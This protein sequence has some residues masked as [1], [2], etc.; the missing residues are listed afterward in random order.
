MAIKICFDDKINMFTIITRIAASIISNLSKAVTENV[1]STSALTIT[2]FVVDGD[3]AENTTRKQR[4]TKK[5]HSEEQCTKHHI[6]FFVGVFV[7]M[8]VTSVD[9]IDILVFFCVCIG[10]RYHGITETIIVIIIITI[11]VV[12]TENIYILFVFDL[13][14]SNDCS[15][16]CKDHNLIKFYLNVLFVSTFFHRKRKKR[17]IFE[18]LA[19]SLLGYLNFCCLYSICLLIVFFLLC[20]SVLICFCALSTIKI[21]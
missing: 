10:A 15:N 3:F 5:K 16:V 1:D 17:T 7:L 19:K 14:L 8:L 21:V 20:F 4:K 12:R 13:R 2:M 11:V 18:K 9:M 6:V